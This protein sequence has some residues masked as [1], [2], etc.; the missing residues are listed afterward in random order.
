MTMLPGIDDAPSSGPQYGPSG[1]RAAPEAD[2]T[3]SM[4]GESAGTPAQKIPDAKNVVIRA[5]ERWSYVKSEDSQNW[6]NQIDDTKFAWVRGEQWN[7]DNRNDREKAD[8]PRP[9]LE[10]NQTGPYVKRI[11]NNQRQSQPAIKVR[12]AGA[13]ATQKIADVQSGMIRAIEQDSQASSVYDTG[14]EN[15]VTGG[16]GYWRV[17]QA[18]EAEDSYNQVLK[19]QA[20]ANASSVRLDPDAKAPD[21]SDIQWG[22]IVDW[23]DAATYE[24]EWGD[25]PVSWEDA[26]SDE[27]N[28]WFNADKVAHIM[29]WLK[30]PPDVPIESKTVSRSIRSAQTQ[31]EQ[32]NFEIRKDLLK[33]DDVMNRQRHVI[34]DERRKVLEG[35]TLGLENE[36]VEHCFPVA[37]LLRRQAFQ[38][39][40]AV[41]EARRRRLEIIGDVAP[42]VVDEHV[43]VFEPL[44]VVPP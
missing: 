7:P 17:V 19:L 3:T 16:R 28:S 26:Q 29:E 39:Q 13:G 43:E 38:G 10:F 8:P 44:D 5:K 30:T 25:D 41:Q 6:Q 15:A 22:F 18:W 42:P 1:E 36:V 14:L 11:T 31:V 24:K 21:K 23:L 33:Y 34:Y 20:C 2:V 32:Q 35:R 4:S 9:W 37:P 12:P 40:E 27:W